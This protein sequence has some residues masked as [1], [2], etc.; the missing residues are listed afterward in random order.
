VTQN[1]HEELARL[2]EAVASAEFDDPY[3]QQLVLARIHRLKLRIK[4]Q[5]FQQE[6]SREIFSLVDGVKK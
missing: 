2:N 1:P 4:G 6:I 3:V 5:A